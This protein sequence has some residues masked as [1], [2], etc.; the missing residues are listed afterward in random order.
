MRR[1]TI[2][3]L[4]A[5]VMG[6]VACGADDPTT[7]PD[8]TAAPPVETTVPDDTDPRLAVDPRDYYDDYTES[9]V[10]MTASAGAPHVPP[11]AEAGDGAVEPMPPEWPGPLDDNVFVDSGDSVWTAVADD[12]ESTFA[13]DVDTGSFTVGRTLLDQGYLPEP[14]SIRVEEW[15]NALDRTDPPP[16]GG[17]DVG[18]NV[19]TH[20]SP[21]GGDGTQLVRIGLSTRP[22]ADEERPPANLTF[23]VD[24]SGSMDIRERL[25]LVKASLALLAQ[26]LR[27]DDTISIVTYGDDASP[28]LA[29]T[30]VREVE[31]IIA[32]I[33]ELVPGGSTNLESGPPARLRAGPLD[34]PGRRTQ[35][36]R[37]GLGRRRQRRR[38]RR[39]RAHRP[40][41][42]GRRGGHPPRH[43]RLRHG[44]LQ[45]PADGAARRHGRRLLQ[46]RRHVRGG[47]AALRRGADPDAERRRRR[48]QGPGAL[49]PG[50]RDATTG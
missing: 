7:A 2:P 35:R 50:G 44:Q 38:H 17:A 10:E 5:I 19:E 13:L 32:A 12:G 31:R 14:D 22:L 8:P 3:L 49:R 36:G 48:G 25:G 18:V 41:H 34:V 29:P 1:R 33:D 6:A 46:L 23:V 45:R 16:A 21:R 9:L 42:P 20:E 40:D 11:A 47:R 28:L 39:H 37:A 26:Q 27:D 43:R 15:V 30:P 4:L 24:T